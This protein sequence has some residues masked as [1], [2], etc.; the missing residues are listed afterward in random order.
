MR[1][2]EETKKN[3]RGIKS[4]RKMRAKEKTKKRE[5]ECLKERER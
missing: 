1:A 4:L 2:R 5:A 3:R